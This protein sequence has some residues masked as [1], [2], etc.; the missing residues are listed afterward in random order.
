MKFLQGLGALFISLLIV[1]LLYITF[2]PSGRAM[3][4]EYAF[5]MER[6]DEEI[7]YTNRKMVEDTARSMIANY[8]FARSE[9]ESYVTYCDTDDKDRCQR[10][11]DA[12]T[13][14]NKTATNYN[15]Y[16]LKNKYLWRNNMPSDIFYE[17]EIIK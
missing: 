9:Y 16:I 4:N 13:S 8:E 5:G 15:N 2:I 11:L 3:F 14:A 7:D 12:K 17:L 6:I 1:L 10:A